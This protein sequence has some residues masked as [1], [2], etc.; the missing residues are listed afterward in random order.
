MGRLWSGLRARVIL[1][2]LVI[3]VVST[4]ILAG[5]AGVV[6]SQVALNGAER[7]MEVQAYL[8]ASALERPWFVRDGEEGGVLT[9]P[10]PQLQT[11]A[12]SFAQGGSGQ[13]TILDIRGNP[14]AY[15]TAS[16]PNNQMKAPE[17][18]A[19]LKGW[20]Q[21]DVRYDPMSGQRMIFA[22][23]PIQRSG[24]VLGIVQVA[25]PLAQVRARTR[26]YWLNLGATAL[27]AALAAAVA[28]WWLA[29]QL[30]GP[31][32]RLRDAATRLAA[33]DLDE[34]VPDADTGGVAE[35]GQLATAFNHMAGRIGDMINRERA[36]VANASH[37]LRTP[38]TNIKLRAEALNNGALDDP[39]VARRFVGEIESEADRLGKM[40]G[41]LLSLSR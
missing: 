34:R 13:L 37:E 20:L 27:L 1:T 19:A 4:V 16:E 10:Q 9:V 2:Y 29:G 21:H 5:R 36:F 40:A 26:S 28:G 7:D 12:G 8:M 17:V 15:S 35:I 23:A 41:D 18:S 33:G 25:T 22:A 39:V 30:V 11:L 31:V 14:L 24:H 3:F 6:F 38:L 32:R